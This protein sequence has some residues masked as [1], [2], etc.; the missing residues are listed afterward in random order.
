MNLKAIDH[1]AVSVKSLEDSFRWYSQ[2]LGF[3]L[4]HK[5]TRTWMIEKY[6][7]KIGLMRRP[8]AKPVDD[9]DNQIAI[10]HFAFGV[11]EDDFQPT[12]DTLQ[13]LGIPFEGPEDTGI[14]FSLFLTDPDGHT[15]EITTYH[16]PLPEPDD[17]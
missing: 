12:V 9:L 8:D 4:F 17:S 15:I 6:G 3:Q 11:A 2:V 16:K 10:Q 13:A 5:F 7:M 1:V 14:A